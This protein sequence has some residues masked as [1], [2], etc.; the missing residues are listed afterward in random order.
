MSDALTTQLL[1]THTAALR[2]EAVRLAADLLR[3][4]Q[5]VALP[6]ETVYGLAAHA[7]DAAAVTRIFAAKERPAT[8]PI[9]VH[10]DSV[11]MARRC[12][13]DWTLLAEQLARAFWPGPLTLVVPRAANM[14]DVV[15]AGGDTVALRWPAH[16]VMQAV[17]RACGFP[18]AAPSAN[19]S[20]RVSPTTAAH[21]LRGLGGRIPLILDGGQCDV[22]IESTVVDVTG[23]VPRI[24]RPGMISAEAIAKASDPSG[25]S[26]RSDRS[27]PSDPADAPRSPGQ[28]PRHYAPAT[29]LE[30]WSWCSR[31]ALM[32]QLRR[33]GLQPSDV[34]VLAHEQLPPRDAGFR[35]VAVI[36]ADPVAYA[37]ALYAELHQCDEA[38]AARVIVEAPPTGPE[39]AAIHDRLRRASA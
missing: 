23:G 8:N 31:E 26:D 37:R 28:M 2:D 7:L 32:E 1:P 17:I 16:P 18:L 39:W 4:G 5:V 22:G 19:R 36:P 20:T 10:A 21:V 6:T 12:A 24:L 13:A 3:A 34:C 35:R 9:I 38:G 15:T 25:R 30:V 29:P 27:D 11:A 33:R 14:P